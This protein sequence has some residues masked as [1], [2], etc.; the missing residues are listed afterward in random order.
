M[1]CYVLE[2]SVDPGGMRKSDYYVYKTLPEIKRS[3]CKDFLSPMFG[4]YAAIWY[5]ERITLHIVVDGDCVDSIDLHPCISFKINTLPYVEFDK[6]DLDKN[7]YYGADRTEIVF[8]DDN[9]FGEKDRSI[10]RLISHE[11][12]SFGSIQSS[13]QYKISRT[14]NR[15][16]VKGE[17]A[18]WDDLNIMDRVDY[19]IDT[20]KDMMGEK[21]ESFFYRVDID[22]SK[23]DIPELQGKK[24]WKNRTID[25][26]GSILKYGEN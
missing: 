16:I 13:D 8:D 25:F 18:S 22:W 12:F 15:V 7:M 10:K 21:N 17:N 2:L 1:S 11:L 24:L 23:V 5:G 4:V 20:K 14:Y 26:Y 9:I 19:D 3:L 6:E